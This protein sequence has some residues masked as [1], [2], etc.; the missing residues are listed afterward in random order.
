V[1]PGFCSHTSLFFLPLFIFVLNGGTLWHLQ[2][3]LQYIKYII[4]ESM[5]SLILIYPPYPIPGKLSTFFHLYFNDF[6]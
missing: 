4:L 5:P 1:L 3:L 6:A 2:K